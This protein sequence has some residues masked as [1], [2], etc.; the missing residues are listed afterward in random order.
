MLPGTPRR[1][2]A[3]IACAALTCAAVLLVSP[4]SPALSASSTGTPSRAGANPIFAK[5]ITQLR[6]THV[7][8]LFPSAG[9]VPHGYAQIVSARPGYY[10]VYVGL[11]PACGE[12]EA[13]TL[14][15]FEGKRRSSRARKPDGKPLQLINGLTGYFVPFSCGA[16]CGPAFLTFDYRR[17]RYTIQIKAGL[18]RPMIRMANSALSAGPA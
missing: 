14:G 4:R 1:S 5:V 9:A 3:S 10:L 13:C 8:L 17:Y 12:A 16:D 6:H 18:R 15:Y 7:P 2:A 11:V